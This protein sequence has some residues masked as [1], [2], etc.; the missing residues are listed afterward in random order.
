MKTRHQRQLAAQAGVAPSPQHVLTNH[1]RAKRTRAPKSDTADASSSRTQPSAQP[2]THVAIERKTQR[3]RGRGGRRAAQSRGKVQDVVEGP[4]NEDISTVGESQKFPESPSET[5]ILFAK[6]VASSQEETGL[7]GPSRD[8]APLSPEE[9]EESLTQLRQQLGK[10]CEESLLT[11]DF[12]ID[13]QVNL[14]RKGEVAGG[15]IH[16]SNDADPPPYK[17]T[18]KETDK[19]HHAA[20]EASGS[21]PPHKPRVEERSQE[22]RASEESFGGDVPPHKPGAKETNQRHHAPEEASEEDVPLSKPRPESSGKRRR[23]LEESSEVNA[24]P[25]KRLRNRFKGMPDIYDENGNLTLGS[26]KGAMASSFIENQPPTVQ[27]PYTED[28][29]PRIEEE[30][31]H[32]PHPPE[33]VEQSRQEQA[34]QT[35]RA[36][37]S[38][39]G[40][41]FSSFLPSAQTVSR[42]IPFSSRR[43]PSAAA[44]S[45]SAGV[46]V[47]P[48]TTTSASNEA[49]ARNGPSTPQYTSQPLHSAQ[50]EPR[51]INKDADS[52]AKSSTPSATDGPAKRHR[53]EKPKKQLLTKGQAAERDRLKKEKE[54]LRAEKERLKQ[55]EARIAQMKKDWEEQRA[56]VEAAQAPGTKRKRVPSPDVIPLPPGGGYG[57]HEDYFYF[58][59]DDEESEQGQDTPSRPRPNK[60]ARLS[61]SSQGSTAEP[62]TSTVYEGGHFL[63]PGQSPLT[64]N[65][66]AFR[67]ETRITTATPLRHPGRFAVPSPSDTDDEGD[68]VEE[69]GIKATPSKGPS[70]QTTPITTN[71]QSTNPS[72]TPNSSDAS[73]LTKQ[74]MPEPVDPVKNARSK[75]MQYQPPV[76]S[77]LKEP[78]RFSI[79][80][81]G[82]DTGG[83]ADE[84]PAKAQDPRAEAE[85]DALQTTDSESRDAH[86]TQHSQP[87]STD[88][89]T[90]VESTRATMPAISPNRLNSWEAQAFDNSKNALKL[91]NI[92]S[93]RLS[94]DGIT[95]VYAAFK[96]TL[97]PKLQEHLDKTPNV[98]Q[99]S[100][101]TVWNDDFVQWKEQTISSIIGEPEN[102]VESP[103]NPSA[104]EQ[105]ELSPKVR[106]YIDCFTEGDDNS[107]DFDEAFEE[108]K[109]KLFDEHIQL[110][111]I[112]A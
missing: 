53:K 19:R 108:H 10:I 17:L 40:W 67:K 26:R 92:I 73:R 31:L 18:V 59:S 91:S 16:E 9:R 63:M 82:S 32:G 101:S 99:D 96:K 105:A 48:A 68:D 55:E 95:S 60:K 51:Q 3:G 98:P 58:D 79:S 81:A 29:V 49:D 1:T 34:P 14:S 52:N 35:P 43:T 62:R 21:A 88:P 61:S 83:D 30:S 12:Q 78:I 89:S 110:P 36:Q 80:T 84:Q 104:Y 103:F 94:E 8:Q 87:T 93:K 76:G 86:T 102:K 111:S 57:L 41:G 42:L 24:P 2:S 65:N 37:T 71:S 64:A 106:V 13:V 4:S 44:V 56:R 85:S 66:N 33:S 112:V 77:K 97:S 20:G 7:P 28:E 107:K 50:T 38:T 46:T 11:R 90:T 22:H 69:Q 75:I 74:P 27:N 25:R 100:G 109:A 39:R 70:S 5:S 54:E 15:E 72:S 45:S 6:V 23:T 47:Q